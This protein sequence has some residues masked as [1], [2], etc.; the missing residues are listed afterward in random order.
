MLGFLDGTILKSWNKL[1][2]I[3]GFVHSRKLSQLWV[4]LCWCVYII[5]LFYFYD[6][7][8]FGSLQFSFM[9]QFVDLLWIVNFFCCITFY[10][11][12]FEVK[13]FLDM[14]SCAMLW[15]AVAFIFVLALLI[16][17][18]IFGQASGIIL[19]LG[20]YVSVG[21]EIYLQT[22]FCQIRHCGIPLTAYW[23]LVTVVQTMEGVLSKFKVVYL[24]KKCSSFFRW[25]LL[26]PFPLVMILSHFFPR[27]GVCTLSPA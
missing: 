24:L 23:S 10:G 6:G 12:V 3:I 25:I 2:I 27:Y 26:F 19:F 14:T 17:S 20:Q 16:Y 22:I 11:H 9:I 4:T 5:I 15:S 1:M 8:D 13:L 7:S 21:Q 18:S